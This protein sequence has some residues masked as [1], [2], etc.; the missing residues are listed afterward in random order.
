MTYNQC[1]YCKRDTSDF[2]RTVNYMSSVL[3][4]PHFM[5][6]YPPLTR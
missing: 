5:E 1:R 2:N 4:R 3:C 6:I